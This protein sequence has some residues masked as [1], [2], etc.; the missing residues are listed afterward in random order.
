[1][2]FSLPKNIKCWV[3]F[4]SWAS[5][6]WKTWKYL[7]LIFMIV[8]KIKKCIWADYAAYK[9][10]LKWNDA[11]LWFFFTFKKLNSFS[12][13]FLNDFGQVFCE[14]GNNVFWLLLCTSYRP[15]RKYISS[16]MQPLTAMGVGERV[17]TLS[18]IL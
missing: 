18:A 2:T 10:S 1:M 5:K 17:R 7:I 3:R 11:I 16:F 6:D 14:L 15:V 13:D 8:T 9:Q 12:S 4:S